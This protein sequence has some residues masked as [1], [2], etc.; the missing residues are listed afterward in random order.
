[1][2]ASVLYSQELRAHLEAIE[3]ALPGYLPTPTAD[4]QPVPEAMLYACEAGGKRL[5]PV[6]VMEFCRLCGGDPKA[7]LPFACALEMIHSYSLVHDD[8]PCMDNSPLR[9]GKPSVHAAFGETMALLAGDALLNRAFEVALSPAAR[10]LVD[11]D[12]AAAAAFELADA[13]G[14]HDMIGGQVMDL[15]C[16][17]QQIDMDTLVTLQAGKTAALIKAACRM[18]VLLAGG[19]EEQLEAATAFGFELGLAFQIVD[20][21]LDVTSTPEVLGKPTGS[22]AENEKTT[23]VSLLGLE[24]ASALAK[25]RTDTALAALAAFGEAGESLRQLATSL[26]TRIA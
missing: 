20:D 4:Y 23:Y 12:K 26:L 22:D 13:A 19:S 8:L 5:R 16:E 21:I 2:G 24:G 17:G 7:A 14:I 3:A 9:R 25:S 18:G 15:R 11:G 1:M 6:L 10:T